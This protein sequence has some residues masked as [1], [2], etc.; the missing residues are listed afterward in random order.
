[1]RAKMKAKAFKVSLIPTLAGAG[2]L[3]SIWA[4]DMGSF[5]T[6][7]FFFIIIMQLS[8]IKRMIKNSGPWY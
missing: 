3:Y 4:R 2:V 7:V 8:N 1:M 6:S 5:I